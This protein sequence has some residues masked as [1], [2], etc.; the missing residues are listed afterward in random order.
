MT[1][2]ARFAVLSGALVLVTL[3][4]LA[5]GVDRLYDRN[6]AAQSLPAATAARDTHDFRVFLVV[7]TLVTAGVALA[8]CWFVAGEALRPLEQ[9]AAS[10][11]GIAATRDLRH[12]LPVPATDDQISLLAT[13]FNELLARVEESAAAQ[14]WALDGQRR[15]VADA[16]HE[17][18]SP[19]TTVR[20][21]AQFL[22]AHRDAAGTDREAALRD[23]AAESDRMA[24]MVEGL[25]TLARAD[26]GQLPAM[27]TFDVGALV[28]DVARQ[29]QRRE[30]GLD[31]QAITVPARIVG[32]AD[33]LRQLCWILVDN[34]VAHADAAHVWLCV[35]ASG[36]AATLTAADDGHGFPPD[37]VPHVFERFV[38]GDVARAGAGAGRGLAIAA[39]IAAQHGG[40]ISAANRPEGGATVVVQL[41]RVM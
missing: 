36:A 3:A 2:R 4:V 21:N 19:L 34:A 6:I 37:V 13:S 30:T 9:I 8:A 16:S 28:E 38:R 41:S 12:R 18:R 32:N 1:I 24:R 29:A 22:L 23:I 20:S 15:F 25:L 40:R 26:A 27:T 14:A 31:V 10:V 11:R 7:V 33:A 39:T 5:A 35:D 17:L